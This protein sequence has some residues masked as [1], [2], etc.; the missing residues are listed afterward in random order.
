MPRFVYGIRFKTVVLMLAITLIPTFLITGWLYRKTTGMLREEMK[1]NQL[2]G[3][4]SA[5]R[6]V[7]VVLGDMDLI[8]SNILFSRELQKRVSVPVESCTKYENYLNSSAIRSE[9]GNLKNVNENI[10]SIYLYDWTNHRIFSTEAYGYVKESQMDALGWSAVRVLT[11]GTRQWNVIREGP[12][13]E[14]KNLISSKKQ[15]IKNGETLFTFFI[16]IDQKKFDTLLQELKGNPQSVYYI[17]DEDRQMIAS[18]GAVDDEVFR[19]VNASLG[20]FANA[21]PEGQPPDSQA[22]REWSAGGRLRQPFEDFELQTGKDTYYIVKR[23]IHEIGWTFVSII[24]TEA[25][26][27]SL[28]TVRRVMEIICVISLLLI[29][30]FGF[31][32]NEL[33][34]VPMNKLISAMNENKKGGPIT[35]EVERQKD[36]FGEIAS[37]FNDLILEQ[38]ELN[39]KLLEQEMLTKNAEIRF[40]QSQINPHFLY[41]ILDNIHWMARMGETEGVA[42]MTFA[43]SRFYRSSLSGGKELVT[44]AEALHLAQA[45]FDIQKVRFHN[46]IEMITEVEPSLEQVFVPK[47]IFQPIIENAISHGV[48]NLEKKGFIMI[49]GVDLGEWVKFL[50]ED[51]GTGLSA[52]ETERINREIAEGDFDVPGNYALKNLNRQLKLL[53]GEGYGLTLESSKGKGTTVILRVTKE[54]WRKEGGKHV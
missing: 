45:Y 8:A 18:S 42:D 39:Q 23:S 11:D 32:M 44:V 19:R 28:A 15:M 50:V 12:S 26:Y 10:D 22:V 13:A 25:I 17:V 29:L 38:H 43:L 30:F 37:N 31:Y 34:Y 53:Y 52:E 3:I 49:S 47:R 7:D 9:L 21:F 20:A 14:N 36:E 35:C 5:I 16:N 2:T 40:L 54:V 33:I 1:Y 27:G 24:P 41:N 48:V 6:F 4:E 51:N 46:R